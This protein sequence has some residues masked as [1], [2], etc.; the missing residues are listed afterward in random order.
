MIN[1][2]FA[3]FVTNRPLAAIAHFTPVSAYKQYLFSKDKIH[4]A[5]EAGV[6]W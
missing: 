1:G 2:C 3:N 5:C 6:C 4:L